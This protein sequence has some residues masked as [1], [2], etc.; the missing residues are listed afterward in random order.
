MNIIMQRVLSVVMDQDMVRVVLTDFD[1]A[2]AQGTLGR[3]PDQVS[4]G[5]I[6]DFH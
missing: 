5:L 4:E 3:V 2:V 1:Q 6:S